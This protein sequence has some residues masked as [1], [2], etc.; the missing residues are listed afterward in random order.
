MRRAAVRVF[1]AMVLGGLVL[2]VA[3]CSHLYE[4]RVVTVAREA[5]AGAAATVDAAAAKKAFCA[6][7]A[8]EIQKTEDATGRFIAAATGDE[9]HPK[10]QWG[11]PD[12]WVSDSADDAGIVFGY[13]AG[14]LEAQIAPS[15]PADL[16]EKAEALVAS[17]RK[18]QDIYT[19]HQATQLE[20]VSKEE[21]GATA[22]AIDKLCGIA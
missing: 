8:Q 4:P 2:G 16:G 10:P 13:A 20:R 7:Y 18:L 12:K 1:M 3:G 5:P 17:M 6:V 14:T 21:Y 11:D 19:N 15:L 9:Q 22:E